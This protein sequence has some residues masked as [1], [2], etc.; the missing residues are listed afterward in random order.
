MTYYQFIHEVEVKVR[1]AIEGNI[2][3]YIH[4]TVKN[5]GTQRHRLTLA[6]KGINIFPT[7]YLEEYYQQFRNGVSVENIAGDIL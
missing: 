5:N 3:V 2:S 4:S 6:E 7:I 1:E